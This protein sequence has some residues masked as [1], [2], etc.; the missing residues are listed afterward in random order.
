MKL[1]G[2]IAMIRIFGSK[3]GFL[4]ESISKEYFSAGNR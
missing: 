2:A 1:N 3:D 4:K